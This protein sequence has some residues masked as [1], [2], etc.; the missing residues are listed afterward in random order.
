MSDDDLYG[1]DIH[2]C[3]SLLRR[4]LSNMLKAG[5]WPE[6]RD[7]PVWRADAISA[8]QEA[9]DVYAPSM[10]DGIDVQQLYEQAHREL[11]MTMDGLDPLPIPDA[12]PMTLEEL[13]AVDP[14]DVE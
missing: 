4:A 13:L 10:H 11:P 1:A 12:C 14:T 6:H 2:L 7:A 3:R 9:R 5:T 8:R